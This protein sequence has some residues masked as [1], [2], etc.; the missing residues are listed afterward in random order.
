M[1]QFDVGGL[2]KMLEERWG[3]PG[4]ILGT[5][6]FAL[7]VLSVVV[8]ATKYLWSELVVSLVATGQTLLSGRTPD[9]SWERIVSFATSIVGVTLSVLAIRYLSGIRKEAMQL[10]EEN[11]WLKKNRDWVGKVLSEDRSGLGSRIIVD[12]PE[13]EFEWAGLDGPD[14]YMEVILCIINSAIFPI[15]IK[16]VEGALFI[17]KRRCHLGATQDGGH[18]IMHGTSAQIRIRQRL[19]QEVAEIIRA[20]RTKGESISVILGCQLVVEAEEPDYPSKPLKVG[21]GAKEHLVS[22]PKQ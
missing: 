4:R 16:G 2:F 19:T 15:L 7:L 18:R 14:A 17:N 1:F 22:I 3:K 21:F 11:E 6:I 10:V 5:I 9:L 12:H 20:S 8:F 13:P